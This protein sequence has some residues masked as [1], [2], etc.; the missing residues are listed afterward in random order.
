VRQPVETLVASADAALVC[1][2][3]F[4]GEG[5]DLLGSYYEPVAETPAGSFS[6]G[7]F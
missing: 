2:L 5:Q 4:D 3:D 6:R 7:F 1:V